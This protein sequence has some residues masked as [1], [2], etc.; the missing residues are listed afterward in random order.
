MNATYLQSHPNETAGY[1]GLI[2]AAGG[3][4]TGVLAILALAGWAPEVL[5]GVATIVFGAALLVQG[6]ALLSEFSRILYPSGAVSASAGVQAA[7][8][9]GISILFVAG[10]GGVVLGIL[11]LL[12]IV[13]DVLLAVAVITYGAALILSSS[14]MR[15]LHVLQTAMRL[16]AATTGRELIAGEMATGSAGLQLLAGL[17][18]LV[19]GI[20]SVSGVHALDLELVGLLVLGI[21]ALMTGSSLAGLVMGFMRSARASG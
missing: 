5:A 17:A 18:V 13:P 6:G 7:T 21:T 4:A 2:D 12:R 19:L 20:L 15:Q 10:A 14:A 11:A 1:G 16:G 8:G 9:E 3:I